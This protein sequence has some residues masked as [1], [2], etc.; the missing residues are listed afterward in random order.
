MRFVI[1]G[2]LLTVL[3][4]WAGNAF[5]IND[6]SGSSFKSGGW[7]A[8]SENG[9]YVRVWRDTRNGVS[10]VFAQLIDSDGEPVGENLLISGPDDYFNEVYITGVASVGD[11]F[12]VVW[13]DRTTR[14]V[15]G[16]LVDDRGNYIGDPIQISDNYTHPIQSVFVSSNDSTYL[17]LWSLYNTST[18]Y[19]I[20][21]RLVDADGIPVG[22]S[23][24]AYDESL[25]STSKNY[26]RSVIDS[27]G[28]MG[29]VWNTYENGVNQ[30]VFSLIKN[31]GELVGKQPVMDDTTVTRSYYPDIAL[32]DSGFVV[33]WYQY[34]NGYYVN[35]Q[36]FNKSAQP[37][38]GNFLVDSTGNGN[39]KYPIVTTLP[40]GNYLVNWYNNN[41]LDNTILGRYFNGG[42]PVSSVFTVAT[43]SGANITDFSTGVNADGKTTTSW[44]RKVDLKYDVQGVSY[45]DS[46]QIDWGPKQ[47]ND[48]VNSGSQS[49]PILAVNEDGGMLTAWYANY[50][51]WY[52]RLDG[53]GMPLDTA[54]N[55][56]FSSTV[57]YEPRIVSGANGT[58]LMVW[59]EYIS[60]TYEVIGALFNADGDTL[61]GP[62][63][64]SVNEFTGYSVYLSAAS[65]RQSRFLVTWSQRFNGYYRIMAQ[66]LDADGNLVGDNIQV[67]Q[68]TTV[69]NYTSSGVI[70]NNGAFSVT[71]LAY[72]NPR[73]V[74]LRVFDETG[75][76]RDSSMQVNQDDLGFSAT[77]VLSA[78]DAGDAVIAFTN[79]DRGY[80]SLYFQKYSAI[81]SDSFAADGPNRLLLGENGINVKEPAVAM[82]DS[83]NTA[84]AWT[85]DKANESAVMLAV[86]QAGDTSALPAFDVY[87]A[88]GMRQTDS[89]SDFVNG[90]IYVVWQDNHELGK[91]YNIYGNIFNFADVISSNKND[92]KQPLTYR[93]KANYP[94]PFNPITRISYQLKQP[95]RVE[96]TVYDVTGRLVKTLYTGRQNAGRHYVDFNAAG[97]ASGLYFYTLKTGD[98]FRQTRKMML[99]K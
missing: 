48:D 21:A 95:A 19:S 35:G 12:L 57:Q 29:F 37:V 97:L 15:Y 72:S 49:M 96:L 83:G 74:L 2:L 52:R 32:T 43:E 31:D 47:L 34:K 11:R 22:D 87:E 3:S 26:P 77:P 5:R 78:N 45:R 53:N 88:Q 39:Q 92:V 94:N 13:E 55:V 81:F 33:V 4:V 70:N 56:S 24:A 90:K 63:V 9:V 40:D 20:Y 25:P 6:F 91:G 76:P 27:E 58:Y 80:Y 60:P 8:V 93:L 98:G 84:I 44:I 65:D 82:D 41:G 23:F 73:K 14:T 10:S 17:V 28:N 50:K 62:F 67:T 18:D 69:N 54:R 38:G 86:I 36:L 75:S 68:D 89:D 16:R 7:A 30:I 64:I 61:K 99:L 46:S 85:A 59:R 51:A 1:F 66:V 71:W 42:E 79:Y